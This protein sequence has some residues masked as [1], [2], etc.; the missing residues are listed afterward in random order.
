[1]VFT[2]MFTAFPATFFTTEV[3][4]TERF[5]RNHL[6]ILIVINDKKKF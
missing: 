3:Q 2:T 4:S 1:M 6:K 5:K